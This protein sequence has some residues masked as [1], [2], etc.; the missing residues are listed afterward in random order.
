MREEL[1]GHIPETLRKMLLMLHVQ[2]KWFYGQKVFIQKQTL[3]QT[4]IKEPFT[5]LLMIVPT[6][7][8]DSS[9]VF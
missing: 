1:S 9:L 5:L 8:S 3:N 2:K 7:V 4:F 6:L